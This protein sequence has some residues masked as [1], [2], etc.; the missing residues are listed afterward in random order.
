LLV[1]VPVDQSSG[2]ILMVMLRRLWLANTMAPLCHV[3]RETST[4]RPWLI[5]GRGSSGER[6]PGPAAF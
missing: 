1:T 2:I 6:W 4:S 3:Y 5:F